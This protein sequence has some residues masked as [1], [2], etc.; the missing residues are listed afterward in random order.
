MKSK[1]NLS[2]YS[3][4]VTTLTI[5][6]F[7]IATFVLFIRHNTVAA[8]SFVGIVVLLYFLTLFYTP[9]EIRFDKGKLIVHRPM[10]NRVINIE[11]IESVKLCPPTMAE[12]RICGSGGFGG[13]WGWFSE[14]DLGR[15]FAYYGKAS[16]CFIVRLKNGRQYM[17]GCNEPGR[18]VDA[19]NAN[20]H[21]DN[22]KYPGQD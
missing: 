12:R 2:K 18:M 13:Y 8:W 5:T 20:L 9:V 6:V 14:R 22:P 7:A 4:I 15:Y 21:F 3:L 10:H 11:S 19:I 1:V 17:I 16:D